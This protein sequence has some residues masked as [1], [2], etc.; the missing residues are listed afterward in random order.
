[1]AADGV[2]LTGLRIATERAH[3]DRL[4]GRARAIVA[5][6]VELPFA[7][8]TF[9]VLTH[10]DLLCCLTDKRAVLAA[11]RRAIRTDGRMAFTGISVAPG[12]AGDDYGRAVSN[13]PVFIETDTDYPT[14]LRET[15]WVVAAK[16]D[17]TAPYTRSCHRQL[18]AD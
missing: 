16:T 17:I 7:D 18:A 12:L 8:A 6:A 15:G 1:M 10:S 5:G 3:R 2:G 13:G 11:C 4:S 14:L 9:D